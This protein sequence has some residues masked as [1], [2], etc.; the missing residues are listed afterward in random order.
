MLKNSHIE[1][2]T[3][4]LA[5]YTALKTQIVELQEQNKSLQE[6]LRLLKNGR[7]SNTSS[8][9]PSQ[10]IGRSNKKNLREPSTRK[11]GGQPG[12]EG[13]TLTMKENPDEIVEHRPNFCNQ[14]SATLDA[15]QAQMVSRK[16]EVVLPP[17]F[18]QYIEHQSYSCTC[19]KCCSDTI[20]ELPEH[21]HANV[22]Y[23]PQVSALVAYFS[24]RQY[25][26]YERIA[27]LM[28][29]CFHLPVSEGTIDN[30][31]KLK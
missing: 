21:L 26:S 18:P 30:M 16:Q 6:Q 28:N 1:T 20:S 17:I 9:P 15:D 5:E 11:T 24:V 10:D 25:L 31:L 7:K 4:S 19:K 22:Q 3:I 23:S 13:A 8:T 14:C 29:D 2:I 27:E 12:H